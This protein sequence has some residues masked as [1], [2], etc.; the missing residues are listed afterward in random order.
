MMGVALLDKLVISFIHSYGHIEF[1]FFLLP[2]SQCLAAA[3]TT[4]QIIRSIEGCT[5]NVSTYSTTVWNKPGLA[6]R[7]QH[8]DWVAHP[9]KGPP[10]PPPPRVLEP[11][12]HFPHAGTA[13]RNSP[14]PPAH[15]VGFLTGSASFGMSGI[16]LTSCKS[17]LYP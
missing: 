1:T 8:K 14:P 12:Q 13:S 6:L 10:P 9:A 7:E 5:E 4:L 16:V 17:N 15:S 11:I 3:T 2:L